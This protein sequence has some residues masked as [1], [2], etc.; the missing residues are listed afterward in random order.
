MSDVKVKI[1]YTV[2]VSEIPQEVAKIYKRA[3]SDLKAV[4]S[5]CDMADPLSDHI[6]DILNSID[7]IRKLLFAVD[8]NF[9]DCVNILVD[10]QRLI[11]ELHAPLPPPMVTDDDSD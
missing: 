5:E 7:K 9:G 11:A 1:A 10:Y 6:P 4:L 3:V 8:A 2:S